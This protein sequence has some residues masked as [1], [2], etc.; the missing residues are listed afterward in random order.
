MERS[1][2]ASEARGKA[3]ERLLS[4]LKSFS[5]EARKRAGVLVSSE[6]ELP[7]EPMPPRVRRL[8]VPHFEAEQE[9]ETI[10]EP[11]QG[12]IDPLVL[13]RQLQR[14]LALLQEASSS[15]QSALTCRL[16]LAAWRR[17]TC[18]ARQRR[19][20]LLASTLPLV[21]SRSEFASLTVV[22]GSWRNLAAV[23]GNRRA[24]STS[25]LRVAGKFLAS[26]SSAEM[27][28]AFA[29]WHGRVCMHKLLQRPR[30]TALRAAMAPCVWSLATVFQTWQGWLSELQMER[31][32]R[33]LQEE[34]TARM[35][36]EIGL[37][38]LCGLFSLWHQ[39]AKGQKQERKL[40]T[41]LQ[42][43]SY[44]Q[45]MLQCETAKHSVE[46]SRWQSATDSLLRKLEVL[47]CR[48]VL[49]AWA[50]LAHVQPRSFACEQDSAERDQA[51]TSLD[52]QQ[53]NIVTA[54]LQDRL[55]RSAAMLKAAGFFFESSC[56]FQV[57]AVFAAWH[58]QARFY[59]LLVALRASVAFS[60]SLEAIF[61]TWRDCVAELQL[62]DRRQ[63]LQDQLIAR[64]ESASGLSFLCGL[65]SMW[66]QVAKGQH[67]VR[68]LETHLQ[69]QS[70]VQNRESLQ[71]SAEASRWQSAMDILLEKLEVLL[72]RS[73]L[74]EWA[75]LVQRQSRDSDSKHLAAVAGHA[76][77]QASIARRQASAFRERLQLSTT[78]Q[79][80]LAAWQRETCCV[81]QRRHLLLAST[82]PLVQGRGE[83]AS[84]TVVFG[85]WRNLAAVTGNRQALSTS[86]LRVAGKFLASSSS[87]E[88]AAAFAAWHG[89]VCMHKLL[90]RPRATALRAAMAPCVWSL[91]TIFQTWQGWLSELQME[92]RHRMLQ[93]QLTARLESESGLNF[94]CGLFSL[95]HQVAKGQKQERKLET[96]LQQQSYHQ[97]IMQNRGSLQESA[98]TSLWRS[99]MDT[100]LCRSVLAEW[101]ACSSCKNA[102]DHA[103][104]H[105]R[106]AV[107]QASAVLLRLQFCTTF[108]PVLAA[109]QREACFLRQKRQMLG[110]TVL[111]LVHGRSALAS[112]TITFGAWRDLAANTTKGLG[113]ARAAS[114][115]ALRAATHFLANCRSSDMFAALAA[116]Q[117]QARMQ[118]L[119]LRP[120][121]MA[122]RV[123]MV[124]SAWSLAAIFRAWQD[125]VAELQR[126]AKHRALHEQLTGRLE[127]ATGLDFLS[128]VISWWR[129][130]SK[131]HQSERKLE[132]QLRD[133]SAEASRWRSAMDTLLG[134][135][136]ILLCR[137][138]LTEWAALQSR[139]RTSDAML[140][141]AGCF[142]AHSCCLQIAAAF[143]AWQ[144]LAKT[145]KLLQRPRLSALRAV[146]VPSWSLSIILGDW[147][148]WV[149]E[150][151]HTGRHRTQQ[152]QLTA[153]LESANAMNF[154]SS[155]DV[156]QS[157]EA[158]RWQ[159]AMQTYDGERS[160]YGAISV[161]EHAFAVLSRLTDYRTLQPALAAWQ[162]QD[163]Q[164]AGEAEDVS[165]ESSNATVLVALGHFEGLA[166]FSIMS[167]LRLAHRHS[168][169][170]ERD[171]CEYAAEHARFHARVAVEQA[172]VVLLRLQ[173]QLAA[174]PISRDVSG[175][176]R[177]YDGERSQ[178]GA[179][180]VM[181][182]A[183]A[184]LSRLTDYRTLQ[185]ALAAWQRQVCC[186]RQKRYLLGAA[187]E[188]ML[189]TSCRPEIV[190]AFAAWNK[191]TRTCKLLA[192]PRM[193]ALR[194]AMPP[195]WSL[196]AILK[197]WRDRVAEVQYH[198]HYDLVGLLSSWKQVSRGQQVHSAQQSLPIS[199]RQSARD[200]L[201]RKLEG[202]I[203]R[204]VLKEWAL[205]AHRHS[206]D[207][208]RDNCEYAAEHARFHA[209]V[210]VEQASV[211][212][213]RLQEQLAAVPISRDV[214]GELRRYDGERSQYG[215]IFVM[216]HA[217]AVLSR[218]TDY[219]TLQP[220]LAAWQRQVS[221]LRQKRYLLGAAVKL[222]LETS[223]RPEIVAAFAAWNKRTRTC[224]LL[225]RPRMLALRAAMPPFWSL[226]AILR[227]WRDRVAEV[228]YHGHYDLVGLLSSWK[229]VSRG[230]QVHS[231]QQSLPISPRQSARDT[232]FRKLEGL[233]CRAVLKEWALLAHR[234]SSDEE[235]DNCEYAAE[236]A[237]LQARVAVEQ[238]TVVLLRLE[239]CTTFHPVFAAW[240]RQVCC[241]RQRRYVLGAVVLPLFQSRS[242]LAS[243]TV[244]FGA[245][246]GQSAKGWQSLEAS[247]WQSAMDT[248]LTKLEVLLCRAVLIEWAAFGNMLKGKVEGATSTT[249]DELVVEKIQ[250]VCSLM[251]FA[252]DHW[253]LRLARTAGELATEAWR[254]QPSIASQVA[255][256]VDAALQ[257]RRRTSDAILKAAGCF[258]AH[259]CS[260]Q[261]AA[262]FAAWQLLA[263]TQKLLQRPRLL[264]LGA[265]LAQPLP[266]ALQ[267]AILLAWR[268]RAL[269][270]RRQRSLERSR[271]S[272]ERA[273]RAASGS[274]LRSRR[275]AHHLLAMA[276]WRQVAL[277]ERGARQQLVEIHRLRR[278]TMVQAVE[279][280]ESLLHKDVG[281]F[282][283]NS[284]LR[285]SLLAW[286][287]VVSRKHRRQSEFQLRAAALPDS[288]FQIWTAVAVLSVWRRC[289]EAP[290]DSAHCQLTELAEQIFGVSKSPEAQTAEIAEGPDVPRDEGVASG[291]DILLM[292]TAFKSWAL[293]MK[294]GTAGALLS[295]YE[296]RA[297]IALACTSAVLEHGQQHAL[298]R[299]VLAIW[300]EQA[301]PPIAH[302][303]KRTQAALACTSAALTLG[304]RRALL[305]SVLEAWHSQ[306]VPSVSDY[307]HRF[308]AALAWTSAALD[309]SHHSALLRHVLTAWLS[310]ASPLTSAFQRDDNYEFQ[311]AVFA[312]WRDQVIRPLSY[313]KQRTQVAFTSA[314]LAHGRCCSLLRG[315]LAMW[316]DA[317]PARIIPVCGNRPAVTAFVSSLLGRL[318]TACRLPV[319]FSAWASC[320]LV[321][322][323]RGRRVAAADNVFA[324]WG[325]RDI[326]VRVLSAWRSYSH[327]V[328]AHIVGE[329]QGL[330][331]GVCQGGQPW[332]RSLDSATLR[333]MMLVWRSATSALEHGHCYALV[334]CVFITWRDQLGP[335]MSYYKQRTQV[336]F[337]SAVLAH[338]RCCSL[339]RGVLAM[340]RDAVPARI[341]PVCGNRPAVTAFVSS[342]LG[343]LDTACRLPVLFSAWA[344]CVLVVAFRGR[345]VA[346]A[347]NV[348]A[349]WGR[350]DIQVRVLSAWRSY[351]HGVRAHI[352]GEQQGLRIGVCQ[353]GQP[354]IRS[355]DSATLRLMMLVWRSATSALEH[356]HC[357]ALVHCVFITWRDQ[358]G[359]SMSY[360]KQRTQV[361][362]TSAVLA[363]GRCCSLLRGVLAMWRDAVP[364]RI[365]PVCGNRPAVTAFVSS[366]LGRLDTA[367]RLRVLFSAWASCV[368]VVASRGRRVA[369]A[370]NVFAGWGRRDVQVRVLSAW[371]SYSHGVRAHIVGEQQVRLA[372]EALRSFWLTWRALVMAH[373]FQLMEALCSPL[374]SSSHLAA[375]EL[376][377][378]QLAAAASAQLATA[379]LAS[380][381]LAAAA[382]REAVHLL[383]SC[384]I[385]WRAS[386]L[387]GD[388]AS[389]VRMLQ[390]RLRAAAAHV[391]R[392]SARSE[393]AD[394]RAIAQEVL[395]TWKVFALG[396]AQEQ[397][398]KVFGLVRESPRGNWSCEAEGGQA[399]PEGAE[400]SCR[401]ALLGNAWI[402]PVLQAWRE[403]CLQ[404]R[405]QEDVRLLE[406]ERDQ[407]L[408]ELR[409]LR[410]EGEQQ[411]RHLLEVVA[412]SHGSGALA[413]PERRSSSCL[414]LAW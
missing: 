400:L 384:I 130:V 262:A 268:E 288:S 47:L 294:T 254:L 210:A 263:K 382:A 409:R 274:V 63:G 119:L 244:M 40:E 186:L 290:E 95:W 103:R 110:D 44:Q 236:H 89:R 227:A 282:L 297:E 360:Y 33:M 126:R 5:F 237:R 164:A 127:L 79:H 383:R 324:G 398:R 212:L 368:L 148:D 394:R 184:V 361:A 316:R 191:R 335:S 72:C 23:A 58:W 336:A 337:T 247:R 329:Q 51:Q 62:E 122:L 170:E 235:R 371:R 246:R 356:G 330:R 55:A 284:W 248:L 345:R 278:E 279:A 168:S 229:Q 216:E 393:V 66:H 287:Q 399:P 380:G 185:P 203:C 300:R 68:K 97:L 264:V 39:V 207:E 411:G 314:V 15:R 28:A 317:V 366:L 151:R 150:L 296:K 108:Q 385:A 381:R 90:Q 377:A 118:K 190:A 234:H 24:Q 318:D 241:L 276:S 196:S 38:F 378:A 133:Q 280:V 20:L 224:K 354:W 34:L 175:E 352:V 222:M 357:Y 53:A 92:C 136:E 331:I 49:T 305:R 328:R 46:A 145:H 283:C 257:S 369:A 238:A 243:L 363:H 289:C 315:V 312:I 125:R 146:M 344:S 396:K 154:L 327:G 206:S 26:S 349:G 75:A 161:M 179:I 217:S 100:L 104:H 341:I 64:L 347:D 2:K 351:S 198:G 374:T 120:R 78:C 74:T 249:R 166:G 87:A 157:L 178:Y 388:Y 195:F 43:H 101:A 302:Y 299:G 292:L 107:E 162:R 173:E 197:A 57:A 362:F 364:A 340:W 258:L 401:S 298:V 169:D 124:Q 285:H 137:S 152:A 343:R 117:G 14:R 54:T 350:R 240:Q 135:L 163:M 358:L 373:T 230:Q 61:G 291:Q 109:W 413:S 208:E 231:A 202:L 204:A 270:L 77:L 410:E 256:S 85:S 172:S 390:K 112:L 25:A 81:R 402:R 59:K 239:T 391:E 11:L 408:Q 221:C 406:D 223:C 19:H 251:H 50:A 102:A 346:A 160:Q 52:M 106:V 131:G 139:R 121:A 158:S 7:A 233:I 267:G 375:A 8:S 73:V 128:G 260:L 272:S 225:V 311:R 138:V 334:H 286:Q 355:L 18:C 301:I 255:D 214:S 199:P 32:H 322:A 86:A 200:T 16:I 303:Q 323:S 192:R 194:A 176:L 379:H 167:L 132:T 414:S 76:Q 226:S 41:H 134:K 261:V 220:A 115:S 245:W 30:A 370:D 407:V 353:G 4:G 242:A 250:F 295:H 412:L 91:A 35:A 114:A 266:R 84:L 129:Q 332:I 3:R 159:S 94:L 259:G 13:E 372:R 188:L 88:M 265:A 27:A 147:R 281:S 187:V 403:H 177:R 182:H 376:A 342:L 65:L 253:K 156:Q 201:F 67:Q 29:A 45:M 308:K 36:S 386:L 113:M 387:A 304:H 228:Q 348:F 12:L 105:A 189:E 143:A 141:A 165:L 70:Y 339:L 307:R 252:L 319:L 205:L 397:F 219:R 22:F 56:T 111:P 153:R 338:G 6:G 215:A 155:M 306:A 218:L 142:L 116:W 310:Q 98:E 211:V 10:D 365:I 42:Q 277:S 31:R 271:R 37:N 326:Q 293:L 181:E 140:K 17:E 213:L 333:L 273:I 232:L 149:A 395:L 82:L 69:E 193:L 183:S 359:P 209:R 1:A 171:N 313:Y 389:D 93:E 71:Q 404:V 321:V 96:H 309:H 275:D 180:S 99:A 83:L 269:E 144:L 48:T 367:C 80:V 325:R 9:A 320:V 392:A 21:Q 405:W 123:T 60:W 174:V